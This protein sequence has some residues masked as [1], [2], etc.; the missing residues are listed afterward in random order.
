MNF[1][2]SEQQLA[3]KDAVTRICNDFGEDY[4]LARD[5]DG[6]F[7]EE[8]VKAITEGGW[9]GIAMP[10]AYGGA[11]LGITETLKYY[12]NHAADERLR[13]VNVVNAE[14]TRFYS[15]L[16]V[17]DALFRFLLQWHFRQAN[18]SGEFPPFL[19]VDGLVKIILQRNSNEHGWV[20]DRSSG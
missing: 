16:N 19:I 14:S 12:F 15:S 6:H 17:F 13:E 2:F 18:T 1:D 7:P 11:G 3:V 9:L 5:T 10:E 20:F 4:W 8:F